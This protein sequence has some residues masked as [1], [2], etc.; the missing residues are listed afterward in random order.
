MSLT[1]GMQLS[2]SV[3]IPLVAPH[4][5]NRDDLEAASGVKKGH[6]KQ[7]GASALPVQR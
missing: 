4:F 5:Y 2:P 6:V 7:I 1:S 3:L